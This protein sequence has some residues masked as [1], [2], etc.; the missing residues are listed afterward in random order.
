MTVRLKEDQK[1]AME[2][3]RFLES[4]LSDISHQLRTPLTSMYVMND[5]LSSTKM[6]KEKKKEGFCRQRPS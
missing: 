1:K 5:L 3:N 4:T 2:Q 6:S